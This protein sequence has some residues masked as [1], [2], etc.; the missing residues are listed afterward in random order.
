VRILCFRVGVAHSET[1]WHLGKIIILDLK[2]AIYFLVIIH[3]K[4][5]PP[6]FDLCKL[7]TPF[8]RY[9]SFSV[10]CLTWIF[11]ERV[12]ILWMKTSALISRWLYKKKRG[13]T[14]LYETSHKWFIGSETFLN[15]SN[16]YKKEKKDFLRPLHM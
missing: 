9:N 7:W 8:A 11:G 6:A 12:V 16:G 14:S 15:T 13:G 2:Y 5:N 1:R 4:T 10:N 3:V